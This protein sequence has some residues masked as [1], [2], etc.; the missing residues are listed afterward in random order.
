MKIFIIQVLALLCT[1]FIVHGKPVTPSTEV[2][3]VSP[4]IA[5][6]TATTYKPGKLQH[7]VLFRY[8][9]QVTAAKRDEVVQRFLALQQECMRDGKP[10]LQSIETGSQNSHEGVAHGFEDA[11]I[12]TFKSEGDRNYYVGQPFVNDSDY[13]DPAHQKFKDFVGPLLHKPIGT[14][15]VLVF[16]FTVKSANK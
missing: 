15:G 7:I 4:D 12:V 2:A 6:L 16:D 5:V 8:D 1:S 10:Y 9:Q 14:T 3:P 11:F 13:Y